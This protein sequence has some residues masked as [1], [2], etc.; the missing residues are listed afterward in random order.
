MATVNLIFRDEEEDGA[1][2][3]LVESDPP[4]DFQNADPADLTCAQ[5]AAL[6]A[7]AYIRV[8]AGAG[9]EFLGLAR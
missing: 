9:V 4:I 2:E 1:F 6:C 7:M 3:M 5:D 8:C